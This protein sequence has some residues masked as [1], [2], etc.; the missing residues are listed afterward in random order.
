MVQ[1]QKQ[2][3]ILEFEATDKEGVLRELAGAVHANHPLI[4]QATMTNIL[5]ERELLGS[6]GV[7]NGIAI[8]H[9]KVPGLDKLLLCLGRSAAGVNFDALDNRPVH[10]FMMILSPPD[11]AGEYLQTL[12]RTSKVFKDTDLRNQI[13]TAVDAETIVQLFNRR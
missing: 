1:L 10:L 12:A 9:G 5:A 2:C 7:G 11:M 4:D 13:L 3:I 6:T 8:P